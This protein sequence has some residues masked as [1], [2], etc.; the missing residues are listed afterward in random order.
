MTRWERFKHWLGWHGE[1]VEWL[2]GRIFTNGWYQ[3]TY[4]CPHCGT[5]FHE[6]NVNWETRQSRLSLTQLRNERD[7]ER[8]RMN[9]AL[10][11]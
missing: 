3:R 8:E 4:Y 1:G 9:K 5:I 2:D 11:L 7:A 6:G 10:G